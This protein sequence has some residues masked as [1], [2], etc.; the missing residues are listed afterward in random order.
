MDKNICPKNVQNSKHGPDFCK[1]VDS[2]EDAAKPEKINQTL[3]A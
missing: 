3:A 2:L 1:K